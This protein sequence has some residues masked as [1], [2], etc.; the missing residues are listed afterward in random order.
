[1][2]SG[3]WMKPSG[4]GDARTDTDSKIVH[5]ARASHDLDDTA[6]AVELR[7]LHHTRQRPS[8]DAEHDDAAASS[9]SD[10]DN[11]EPSSAT[12]IKPRRVNTLSKNYTAAE[13]A[14]VVRKLDRR[15]TLFLAALY[16]LSFLDR[17][18]IGNARIAGLEE[19]LSLSSSQ[20]DWLLT[21]FYITYIGFEWMIL[22]YKVLP[23]RI[24]I[25]ACVLSWGL[26]A[27]L[28]SLA[29]SFPHLLILRAVLGVTE[30]AFGPGV[31]FYM[32]FFY[33]RSELAYRV[34]L[35]ISAAPLAT[36]FA[37]ALAW[38]ILWLNRLFGEPVEGWR[39]LFLVEGFP[40]V[41]VGVA[42]LWGAW[43]P[44]SPG[45]A[46]WLSPRERR[47]AV[48]RL[49]DEAEASSSRGHTA[50]MASSTTT[51]GGG[52]SGPKT[53]GWRGFLAE[54]R[55][56]LSTPLPYL[57]ALMFLSVNVSFASLPVF[58]PTVIN[59]MAFSPLASQALSAPPYLAA[60]A[61]VLL[62]S[63]RSDRVPHS[64]GLF[65]A[66]AAGLSA[67]AYAAIGL[68]GWCARRGWIATE[69]GGE[70]WVR[71]V[72]VWPAAMGMF[73]SVVMVITWT[74]NN[75][76]GRTGKGVAM[77]VLNVLGQCGP[78]IGVHLFPAS[79]SP[80]FVGGM[81]T[82]AAFMA[83]VAALA[84]GLRWYLK[85]LNERAEGLDGSGGEEVEL[86]ERLM[87]AEAVDEEKEWERERER[88][89]FKYML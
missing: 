30:A 78:L 59:S 39:V 17:S 69:G 35:Q 34:G 47:V 22:L 86:Q 81:L 71:Y 51:A 88:A 49:Q 73:A 1:M 50:S 11:D 6:A 23:P 44:D 4:D 2:A 85:V 52:G 13:E 25:P 29:L 10:T 77:T 14:Q 9:L 16:L 8:R 28:Q 18:N 3:S 37:S 54:V 5:G 89:G 19:S 21:A 65:L 64:R 12:F 80:F 58:L 32:T 48:L 63:R 79:A 27:S 60:F 24:Y 74:L 82:S 87:G 57:Q 83:G 76:R 72:L 68:V 62:L 45:S 40:S 61:F 20:F 75:Q 31:P 7:R 55:G 36:S 42:A 43:V 53:A 46:K 56:T 84:V 33:R 41:L 67:S 26:T 66:G 15:L 70:R 38:A